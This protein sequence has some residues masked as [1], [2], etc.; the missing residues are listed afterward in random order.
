MGW[1]RRS[2][3]L[4]ITKVASILCGVICIY[5]LGRELGLPTALAQGAIQP[6][7]LERTLFDSVGN[8]QVVP[9]SDE[10]IIVRRSDGTT[11][12]VE[13]VG[14]VQASQQVR[15][16]SYIDGTTVR[17]ADGVKSRSTFLRES[18]P[19]RDR[20]R[21]LLTQSQKDCGFGTGAGTGTVIGFDKIMGLDVVLTQ[22]TYSQNRVTRT[23]APRL[24][25]EDLYYKTEQIQ[26]DGSFKL[27][28]ESRLTQLTLGE[29]NASWFSPGGGFDEVRPSELQRRI[30]DN[31]GLTLGTVDA[32]IAEQGAAE[33]DKQYFRK[34]HENL[35]PSEL[36]IRQMQTS[37]DLN[38]EQV[39]RLKRILADT[40]EAYRSLG[41]AQGPAAVAIRNAHNSR[42]REI[43]TP[44]Q[45]MRFDELQRRR[46]EGN[47]ARQG[48]SVK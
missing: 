33:L 32:R 42:V 25:C 31:L 46:K 29:P 5:Y 14:T 30:I 10:E 16:I 13:R 28:T 8:G 4:S 36:Y 9:S 41:L 45:Q 3:K 21:T 38:V 35:P 43:L 7:Y 23:V 22:R 6:F 34:P 15:I 11:V 2:W 48:S 47:G 44:G 24:G 18:N 39:E 19:N 37:L 12:R 26:P 1:R 40:G 27:I 20:L 17:I